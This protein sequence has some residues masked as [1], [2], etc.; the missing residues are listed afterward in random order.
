MRKIENHCCGCAA[1]GYPCLGP[2]CPN[3]NVEVY[4]CDK[5]G[6]E[7]YIEDKMTEDDDRHYHDYCLE[8]DED[9]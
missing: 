7:I 6:G 5:C 1:P 2:T 3:R 4:Y 9:D 8:E